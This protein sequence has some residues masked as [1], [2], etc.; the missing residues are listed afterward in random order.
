MTTQ[1]LDAALKLSNRISELKLLLLRFDKG[2]TMDG[3][4]S[5]ALHSNASSY[6]DSFDFKKGMPKFADAFLADYRRH[7]TAQLKAAEMEFESI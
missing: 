6:L 5:I 7:L 4:G 1:Q 2:F 3:T